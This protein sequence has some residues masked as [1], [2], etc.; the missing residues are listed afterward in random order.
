[1]PPTAWVTVASGTKDERIVPLTGRLLIGRECAGVEPERRLIFDDPQI[2]RDH[3]ELRSEPGRTSVL[4][5][6]STNGT[7]V[8]GRRVE[9]GEQI[10]IGDG[11]SIDVGGQELVFHLSEPAAAAS[12]AD[13]HRTIMRVGVV[14]MAIVVADVVGYTTLTETYGGHDVAAISDELFAALNQLLPEHGGTVVNYIGDAILA[15]WDLDRD[16]TAAE[17]AIRYA[18]AGHELV[19]ERAAGLPLRGA[20][21]EPLRMGWAVTT[22]EAASGRPSATRQTV[23]GDAVNLAFRLSGLAA[24]DDRPPILVTEEAVA[25]APEAARFGEP[26]ELRV[27]G[28]AAAARVVGAHR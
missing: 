7:W 24:R 22:G 19:T 18:L 11:D 28:R 9:R 10:R 13:T 27:K 14:K 17:K 8:N 25:L 26:Q 16:P 5:D 15:G 21:G 6:M 23:H 2:S 3:V 20:D 4:V 1:V 12:A